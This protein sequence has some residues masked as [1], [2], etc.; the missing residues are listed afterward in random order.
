[1][2]MVIGNVP[3]PWLDY[4]KMSY[5]RKILFTASPIAN[6]YYTHFF[7][8]MRYYQFCGNSKNICTIL[9]LQNA[10]IWTKMGSKN[11]YDRRVESL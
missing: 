6:L 3:S 2:L 4:S 8:R 9:Y 5:C 11:A 10:L 1:M 7:I